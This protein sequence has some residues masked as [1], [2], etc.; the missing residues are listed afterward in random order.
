M[1]PQRKVINRRICCLAAIPFRFLSLVKVPLKS[2]I[3][4]P[5]IAFE[6]VENTDIFNSLIKRDTD[7]L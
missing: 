2:S 4:F 6:F 1:F 7:T 3:F 5:P